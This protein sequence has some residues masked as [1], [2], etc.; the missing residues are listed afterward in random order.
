MSE[1]HNPAKRNS[2]RT[3]EVFAL[4]L[5]NVHIK[6]TET[7]TMV[8]LN[9]QN[10]V[11]IV[12]FL[13]AMSEKHNPAIRNSDRTVEVFALHQLNEHITINRTASMVKLNSDKTVTR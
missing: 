13:P 2:N 11:K 9:R 3:V 7:P 6:I 5:L 1:K 12:T 10:S 8:K 4:H